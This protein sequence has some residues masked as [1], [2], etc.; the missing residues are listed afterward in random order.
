MT[1]ATSSN[2]A[3][4]K[5]LA[6]QIDRLDAIVDG[7]ADALLDQRA[8]PAPQPQATPSSE[9]KRRTLKGLLRPPAPA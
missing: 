5:S 9:P 6:E 3:Q 4:R 7:L 2:G 8:E 1:S